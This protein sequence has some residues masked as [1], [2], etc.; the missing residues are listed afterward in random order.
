MEK[1]HSGVFITQP[2]REDNVSFGV[3]DSLPA[4][5]RG[6][7]F[8]TVIPVYSSPFN[9]L[10]KSSVDFEYILKYWTSAIHSK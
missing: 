3:Q 4:S 8:L 7:A 1:K 2:F 9:H 10:S 5:K 6:Y